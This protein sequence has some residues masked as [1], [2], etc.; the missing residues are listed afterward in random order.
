MA[1]GAGLGVIVAAIPAIRHGALLEYLAGGWG[2][3]GLFLQ[4][5]GN[6][7][8]PGLPEQGFPGSL[9]YYMVP[10]VVLL[11]LLHAWVRFLRGDRERS[12]L[13]A[14]GIYAALSYVTVLVRADTHHLLNIMPAVLLLGFLS[15]DSW[16]STG[17]REPAPG[18]RALPWVVSAVL[19]ACSLAFSPGPG[20]LARSL[21]NRIQDPWPGP[22]KGWERMAMERGGL[23]TP[24]HQW[25][26]APAQP[27]HAG[28]VAMI[29]DLNPAGSTL[30][31]GRRASLY[32]FLTG[33]PCAVPFTD[34]PSQCLTPGNRKAL[35]D[36]LVANRPR[37]V[38]TEQ[39]LEMQGA[40]PPSGYARV[41]AY[42][43]WVCFLRGDLFRGAPASLL[44]DPDVVEKS[45]STRLLAMIRTAQG[46]GRGAA[47]MLRGILDHEG[48]SADLRYFL[49]RAEEAA[50]DTSLA[51]NAYRA[52]L[53]LDPTQFSAYEG[54]ESLCR[55]QG[56]LGAAE[57]VRIQAEQIFPGAP[58]V[59]RPPR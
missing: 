58:R 22:T 40:A 14:L 26:R 15:L 55:A 21:V 56:D 28:A 6:L 8:F 16:L 39:V 50:G 5:A 17:E 29:R 59:T 46:D 38:F 37:F 1:L 25:L 44:E 10:G 52:S 57:S 20:F 36:A 31:D 30:L 42:G 33:V 19:F 53:G 41:G 9:L 47:T 49:A 2:I 34:V 45:W 35:L 4:G 27:D 24:P 13:I 54:L 3:P 43:G 23:W 7:R 32:Y 18:R 48:E 11:L 51:L 12:E